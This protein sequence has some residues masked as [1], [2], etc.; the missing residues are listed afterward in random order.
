MQEFREYACNTIAFA[1]VNAYHLRN[2][3]RTKNYCGVCGNALEP[4]AVERAFVCSKC[5]QI[6]YPKISP[7]II[8]AI[9]DGD[10]LLLVH[11]KLG[12]YKKLALVAGYVEIGETFDEAVIREVKEEVGLNVKNLQYIDNQPWGLTGAQM[13][14]YKAEVDGS[15]EIILEERELSSAKWY[16]RCDIPEITRRTS[17]GNE[18]IYRFKHKML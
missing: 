16:K 1:G 7:A 18:M 8:V 2:W 15:R 10:K 13:I 4:S 14:A 5:G 17:I 11:N 9:T 12:N 6:E 3:K